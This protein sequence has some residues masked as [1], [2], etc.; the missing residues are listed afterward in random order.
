MIII[1]YSGPRCS[2][3]VVTT[4]K[5]ILSTNDSYDENRGMGLAS[6]GFSKSDTVTGRNR[7][8]LSSCISGSH[9]GKTI[10]R[11]SGRNP[12]F[13]RFAKTGAGCAISG[14]S[15]VGKTLSPI[16]ADVKGVSAGG[17]KKSR[18]YSISGY[19][20]TTGQTGTGGPGAPTPSC[21]GRAALT[22][23]RGNYNG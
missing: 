16:S 17:I 18:I 22:V 7:G 6:R 8:D 1:V 3:P 19:D 13:A 23:I 10:K 9:T 15:R 12:N 5:A 4:E 2:Y 21:I 14:G 20:T 11:G